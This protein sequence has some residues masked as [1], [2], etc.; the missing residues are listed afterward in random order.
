MPV[1]SPSLAYDSDSGITR[2]RLRQPE[3]S[4]ASFTPYKSRIT[5][6]LLACIRY[7]KLDRSAS[8]IGRGADFVPITDFTF[9]RL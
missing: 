1:S 6:T 3:A 7:G 2:P 8:T 9:G 4:P 5:Q